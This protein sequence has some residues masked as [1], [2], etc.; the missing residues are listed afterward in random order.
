MKLTLNEPM[1]ISSDSLDTISLIPLLNYKQLLLKDLCWSSE[2][3]NALVLPVELIFIA[4]YTPIKATNIRDHKG[5]IYIELDE[6][7]ER[8]IIPLESET[9]FVPKHPVAH[10]YWFVAPKAKL[11][12]SFRKTND[13]SYKISTMSA[14]RLQTKVHILQ[15]LQLIERSILSFGIIPFYKSSILAANDISF[16]QWLYSRN[17]SIQNYQGFITFPDFSW[18]PSRTTSGYELAYQLI[19]TGDNNTSE[20]SSS[21]LPLTTNKFDFPLWTHNFWISKIRIGFV[22]I[23]PITEWYV[24]EDYCFTSLPSTGDIVEILSG[25]CQLEYEYGQNTSISL[26]SLLPTNDELKTQVQALI[27]STSPSTVPKYSIQNSIQVG[28]RP[29]SLLRVSKVSNIPQLLYEADNSTNN[30]I[31]TSWSPNGELDTEWNLQDFSKSLTN[32]RLAMSIEFEVQEGIH[33]IESG[34]V[35]RKTI[36]VVSR[37]LGTLLSDSFRW[38]IPQEM[39]KYHIETDSN[40][41]EFSAYTRPSGA[42]N[43]RFELHAEPL[44][45]LIPSDPT[46]PYLA[47]RLTWYIFL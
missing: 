4:C 7:E 28:Y 18:V 16:T 14:A 46:S 19:F 15:S 6:D 31:D 2:V 45:R 38:S 24:F 35:N 26:S 5:T 43:L 12:L 25:S 30:N 33:R 10:N 3:R 1:Y 20:Y 47:Y 34:F 8:N 42:I 22:R 37:P 29:L 44:D 39:E 27:W 23:Q 11:N 17:I 36:V 9:I 13:T 41:N 21:I 32:V 40:N